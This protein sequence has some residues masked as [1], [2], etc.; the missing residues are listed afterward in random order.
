MGSTEQQ[1]P[2]RGKKDVF[3]K[4]MYKEF[5][6]DPEW[7]NLNHGQS[8]ISHSYPHRPYLTLT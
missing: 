2:I 5:P 3:G 4:A 1:L 7:K 6:F 8:Q